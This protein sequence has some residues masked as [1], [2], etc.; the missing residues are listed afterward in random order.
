LGTLLVFLGL[1]GDVD[2]ARGHVDT[3]VKLGGNIFKYASIESHA[4]LDKHLFAFHQVGLKPAALEKLVDTLITLFLKDTN[5]VLK[6]AAKPVFFHRLD[7][8][9]TLILVLAFTRKDLNVDNRAVDAR[10]A[11]QA[12]VFNVARF[13]TEDRTEKFFLGGQL[14]LAFRR[15]FTY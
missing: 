3:L 7:I 4:L 5:F 2:I 10:R 9:R 1:S 13:F 6:I 8:K 14:C 15:Y 11:G 12:G